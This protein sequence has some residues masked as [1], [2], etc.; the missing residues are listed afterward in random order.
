MARRRLLIQLLTPR[1]VV[2]LTLSIPVGDKLRSRHG[3]VRR[4]SNNHN[5]GVSGDNEDD[6]DDGVLSDG[7]C[8]NDNQSE[9][10]SL[11]DT[12]EKLNDELMSEAD[13][14]RPPGESGSFHHPH[15]RLRAFTPS[16]DR[17]RGWEYYPE[18]PESMRSGYCPPAYTMVPPDFSPMWRY[19]PSAA[20][21]SRMAMPGMAIDGFYAPPGVDMYA[22]TSVARETGFGRPFP[23]RYLTVLCASRAVDDRVDSD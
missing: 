9:I 15:Q 7:E 11:L 10:D 17:Y 16:M 13:D 2:L 8:N 4:S 20:S 18:G 21:L 22:P 5:A 14:H 19:P 12:L 23:Q 1:V 3:R 6:G